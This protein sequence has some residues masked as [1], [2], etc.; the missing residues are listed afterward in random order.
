MQQRR[1]GGLIAADDRIVLLGGSTNMLFVIIYIASLVAANLAV[2][3][4]GPA[5]MPVIAFVLIGLDLTLRDRLHDQWR[6]RSLW[7]RMFALIAAA[8]VIS[9][10]M[11]PVSGKIAMA[12]V[13]AFSL[14]SLADAVAYQLLVERS[15]TVRA[16]GSNVAGAAVDSAV[17]PLLAFGTAMPSIVLAQFA[18]KILG[19]MLWAAAIAALTRAF[20]SSPSNPA[21]P[22]AAPE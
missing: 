7:P 21:E 3:H 14:S 2:A 4:F 19:G 6:G 5:A 10:A 11:N 20:G 18:A 8:G 1:R 17:F 16:N 12:S 15:W 9:Y 13:L 22:I